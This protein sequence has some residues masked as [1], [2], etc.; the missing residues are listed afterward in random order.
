MKNV[1]L[2]HLYLCYSGTKSHDICQ[3]K[4]HPPPQ[5]KYLQQLVFKGNPIIFF[6]FFVCL[7]HFKIYW[8]GL[9]PI[10]QNI[11]YLKT[12]NKVR[13]YLILCSLICSFNRHTLN[14]HYIPG[15]LLGTRHIIMKKTRAIPYSCRS[16]FWRG[17]IEHIQY[18]TIWN[19]MFL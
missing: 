5:F 2:I 1:C 19:K 6:F 8:V 10:T 15:I 16:V 3:A 17:I 12:W 13:M 4:V 7:N 18:D 11:L 14:T 9:F